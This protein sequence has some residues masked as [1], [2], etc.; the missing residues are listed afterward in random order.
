[1]GC[2][3]ATVMKLI[4]CLLG[5]LLFT[6]LASAQGA[7]PKRILIVLSSQ[8]KLAN[9]HILPLKKLIQSGYDPVLATPDGNLPVNCKNSFLGA[10]ADTVLSLKKVQE[11]GLARYAAI[12]VP[13]GN[14]PMPDLA[15]SKPLIS[16]IGSFYTLNKP[17]YG[18]KN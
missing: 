7:T 4:L 10:H 9:E 3:S 1:M 6:S 15:Q 2:G 18:V 5:S 16:I 11:T 17:V 8:T 14:K 13:G 12:Y